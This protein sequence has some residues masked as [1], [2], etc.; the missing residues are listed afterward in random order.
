MKPSG[1]FGLISITISLFV[2][3]SCTSISGTNHPESSIELTPYQ[4]RTPS[5]SSSPTQPV[6]ETL[7]P[8]LTPFVYQVVTGDTFSKIAKQHGI[9]VE[10]LLV[11][12]PGIAPESLKIGQN[13]I[14]PSNS[15]PEISIINATPEPLEIGSGFCQPSVGGTTCLIP[16]KNSSI[17]S[18]E[19]VKI[20]VSLFGNDDQLLTSQDAILPLNIL[21]PGQI[22]PVAIFFN[23]FT[24]GTAVQSE[25]VSSARL[26]NIDHRYLA[27]VLQNILISISWDGLSAGIQGQIW[28]P[29]NEKPATTIWLVG[30]AYDANHRIIGFRRWEWNGLHQPGSALPFTLTVY[31]LGPAIERV[32]MIVEARP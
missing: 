10:S 7:A 16:V 12:N 32:E 15:E 6:V 5:I 18:V 31:S 30:V 8:T 26:N 27:T 17:Q 9:S 19:N 3:V 20:H 11:A 28:L 22:L 23:G 13:L 4:T 24:N 21:P 29:E 1:S 14:I 25:L 2:L